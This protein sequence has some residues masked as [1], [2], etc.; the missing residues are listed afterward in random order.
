MS[1]ESSL[2]KSLTKLQELSS[3]GEV[4]KV[5]RRSNVKEQAWSSNEKTSNLLGN[6]LGEASSLAAQEAERKRA[7]LEAATEEA[8]LAAEQEEELKRL[9]AE[10]ALMEEKRIHEEKKMRHTQMLAAIE[11]EKKIET[12]EINLEEEARL[13][14][15]EEE[16]IRLEKEAILAKEAEKRRAK[17]LL[18]DQHRQMEELTEQQ[19]EKAAKKKKSRA[20]LMVAIVAAVVL[21]ASGG[22]V[23]YLT[24]P[25]PIDIYALDKEYP[26]EDFGFLSDDMSATAVGVNIVA[27][28]APVVAKP[29]KPRRSSSAKKKETPAGG[30]TLAK[31]RGGLLGG[32]KGG[33]L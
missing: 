2:S 6:L 4:A 21:C 1:N 28:A 16:R 32:R 24:R 20:G 23:W 19:I 7:E 29:V 17:E 22:I 14:R 18:Q 8:R 3:G 13:K 11:R 12:G 9:E 5:K 10:H 25:E 30:D 31:G 15:E 33:S 27:Q 26:S